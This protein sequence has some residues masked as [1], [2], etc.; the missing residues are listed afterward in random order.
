MRIQEI[1]K[2][3]QIIAWIPHYKDLPEDSYCVS[4]CDFENTD[5]I[6]AV[7]AAV[8]PPFFKE[9]KICAQLGVDNMRLITSID[10]MI[11]PKDMYDI[12]NNVPSIL[13]D[14]NSKTGEI[15]IGVYNSTEFPHETFENLMSFFNEDL[16]HREIPIDDVKMPTHSIKVDWDK[17]FEIATPYEHLKEVE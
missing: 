10:G 14:Y 5:D 4:G 1:D 3:Q 16:K 9:Y 7:A 13:F 8:S 2:K 12:K 17:V 6:L 11:K 15:Q